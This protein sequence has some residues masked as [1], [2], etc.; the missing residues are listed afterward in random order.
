MTGKKTSPKPN[1]LKPLPKIKPLPEGKKLAPCHVPDPPASKFTD[2]PGQ[3]TLE[4][5]GAIE[6]PE[7]GAA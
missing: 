6:L 7:A 4:D 3:L 5:M 2:I 1:R